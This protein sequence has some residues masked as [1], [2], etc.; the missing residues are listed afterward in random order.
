MEIHRVGVLGAGAMG[1]GI[2]QVVAQAGF[3]VVL[4]DLSEA[5]VQAGVGKIEKN[6]SKVLKKAS[7]L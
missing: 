7:F 3:Q 4:M 1:S 5:F 6:L 2:A